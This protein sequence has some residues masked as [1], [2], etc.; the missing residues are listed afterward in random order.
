VSVKT[1]QCLALKF[2]VLSLWGDLSDERPGLFFVIQSQ[3]HF[4]AESESVSQ[5]ASQ[6]V[7]LGI[8]PTLW[9]SDQ[10]LLPF[11]EFGS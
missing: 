2:V 11:Q 7:C 10:R 6:S 8:E 9:T 1:F 3:S 5:S 4:T